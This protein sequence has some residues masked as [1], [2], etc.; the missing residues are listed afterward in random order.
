MKKIVK[1]VKKKIAQHQR[2][3]KLKR[4]KKKLRKMFKKLTK[5]GFITKV[6]II[7]CTLAMLATTV[8]PY[9]LR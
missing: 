5:K 2:E 7:I 3:T 8:L 9:V 6:I 4:V 1:T